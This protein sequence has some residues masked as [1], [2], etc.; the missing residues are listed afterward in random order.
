MIYNMFVFYN[1]Q[2]KNRISGVEKTQL[3]IL[4]RVDFL[5]FILKI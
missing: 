1:L 2:M 4:F 3:G 5:N